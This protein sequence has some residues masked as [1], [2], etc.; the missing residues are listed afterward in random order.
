[1]NTIFKNHGAY[2]Q[3]TFRPRHTSQIVLK[4]ILSHHT[5]CTDVN[6]TEHLDAMCSVGMLM[7]GAPTIIP[8]RNTNTQS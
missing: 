6:C 4:R 1:M 5:Y 8:V 7:A 2:F 3:C